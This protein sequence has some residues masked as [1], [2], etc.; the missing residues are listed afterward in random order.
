MTDEQLMRASAPKET[1]TGD[2]DD[3]QLEAVIKIAFGRWAGAT[4]LIALIRRACPDRSTRRV[5]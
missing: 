3:D 4:D 2:F 1:V 5:R